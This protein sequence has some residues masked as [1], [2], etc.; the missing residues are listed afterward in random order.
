MLIIETNWA[1]LDARFTDDVELDDGPACCVCGC[2][3]FA[4]CD[5]GCWWVEDPDGELRDIC[6]GC[7][8]SRPWLPRHDQAIR[9]GWE[10]IPLLAL[11]T[12]LVRE[13]ETVLIRAGELGLHDVDFREAA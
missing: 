6:S 11:A 7:V 13:W 5:G 10:A 2:T 4:A 1:A 12:Q 3:E 9:D 8:D